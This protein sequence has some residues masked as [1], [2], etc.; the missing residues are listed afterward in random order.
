MLKVGKLDIQVSE[1]SFDY[2][3]IINYSLVCGCALSPPNSP[4]SHNTHDT[5]AKLCPN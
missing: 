1:K 2:V 5:V 4:F 3:I